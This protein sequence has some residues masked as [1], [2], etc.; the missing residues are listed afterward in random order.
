MLEKD[1]FIQQANHDIPSADRE[2]LRDLRT[3]AG[4]GDRARERL[5]RYVEQIGNPYCF[6]VGDT[7]VQISFVGERT[8]EECLLSYFTALKN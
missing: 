8:L 1:D 5:E 6:R 2:Q 4:R 3:A 7:P